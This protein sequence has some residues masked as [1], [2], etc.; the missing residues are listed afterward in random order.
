MKIFLNFIRAR[1]YYFLL[2][3]IVILAGFSIFIYSNYNKDKPEEIIMASLAKE[4][5]SKEDSAVVEQDLE[6]YSVDIKGAVKKPGVYKIVKGSRIIDVIEYAG[7][8]TKSAYTNNINLSK[9]VS[10]EMVIYIYTKN[11]YKKNVKVEELNT[12][13]CPQEDA[14]ITECV[15]NNSSV[16]EKN[17]DSAVEVIIESVNGVDESKNNK[18]SENVSNSTE[19]ANK[20]I[21]INTASSSDLTSLPGVGESKANNIIKYREENGNFKSIEDI[22]SVSGIGDALFNKIK[23]FITI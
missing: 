11:E 19:E 4:E 17:E 2:G 9:K 23:E 6:T 10:D 12:C 5:I 20:L 22:K 1:W 14:V 7:G 3:L 13:I 21:N 8:L 18:E 16:I 15:E